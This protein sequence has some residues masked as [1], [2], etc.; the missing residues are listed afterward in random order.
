MTDE[1]MERKIEFI[2]KQQESFADNLRQVAYTLK[3]VSERQD[4]LQAQQDKF[5]SQL[6]LLNQATLGLMGVVGSLTESQK[7]TDEQLKELGGRLDI[8]INVVERYINENR[9]GKNRNA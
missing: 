6:E 1:E 2:V 7:R 9:N 5:Q 3:D 4:K 8:F